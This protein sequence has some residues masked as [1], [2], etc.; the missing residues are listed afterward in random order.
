MLFRSAAVLGHRMKADELAELA[1]VIPK[2]AIIQVGVQF[3]LLAG[4]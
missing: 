3:G 2:I 1:R 4:S